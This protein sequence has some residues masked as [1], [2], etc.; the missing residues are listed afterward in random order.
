MTKE[1]KNPKP[2][3]KSK[4]KAGRKKITQFSIL[5]HNQFSKIVCHAHTYAIGINTGFLYAL[6]NPPEKP[7]IAPLP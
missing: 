1:I 5:S 2:Q 7:N 6:K 4:E 3:R